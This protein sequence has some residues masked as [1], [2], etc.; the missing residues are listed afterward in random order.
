[1]LGQL[2][3]NSCAINSQRRDQ[4]EGEGKEGV[5]EIFQNRFIPF[6]FRFSS[7]PEE[8]SRGGFNRCRLICMRD[9]GGI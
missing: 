3:N 4:L 8:D 1:M 7:Q 9:N 6:S 5:I 2:N